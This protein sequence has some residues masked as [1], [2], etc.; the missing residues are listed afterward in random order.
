MN[1]FVHILVVLCTVL[2]LPNEP[3]TEQIVLFGLTHL[4]IV[5]L[6]VRSYKEGL[7]RGIKIVWMLLGETLHGK[8]I[9]SVTIKKR[10]P[11]SRTFD[12]PST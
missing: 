7:Q 10:T 11:E 2:T 5:Y 9:E 4:M 3:T 12:G 1:V 6:M 8:G